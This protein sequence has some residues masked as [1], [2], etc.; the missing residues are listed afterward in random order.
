[1]NSNLWCY[2]NL[3]L[4]NSD[5]FIEI[6]LI[7]HLYSMINTHFPVNFNDFTTAKT[8]VPK[9]ILYIIINV[10]CLL[11]ILLTHLNQ[12]NY[13]NYYFLPLY[14]FHDQISVQLPF[15]DYYCNLN[16]WKYL[17]GILLLFDNVLNG[18]SFS[19]SNS[20]SVF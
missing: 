19:L 15:P 4:P 8:W 17:P 6:P 14:H 16:L 18:A 2:F 10:N 12:F 20:I 13:L 3:Q 9:K 5:K 11:I 1:M 7:F